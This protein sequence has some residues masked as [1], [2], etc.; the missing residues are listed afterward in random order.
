MGLY[1]VDILPSVLRKDLPRIP[2]QEVGRIMKRIGM[3]AENPRPLWS[4][5]LVGREEYRARQG[6]YRILYVINESIVTVVVVKVG[7]RGDVYRN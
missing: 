2:K 7:V 4:K 1:N 5:R 6:N 3:L